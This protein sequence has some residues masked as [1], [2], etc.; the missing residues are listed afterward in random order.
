MREVSQEEFDD[1]ILRRKQIQEV[2][3][4][5]RILSNDLENIEDSELGGEA[6]EIIRTSHLD[7]TGAQIPT[8]DA[9]IGS[10]Y[11]VH[12]EDLTELDL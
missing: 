4:Y 1:F 12:Y 3:K 6:K 2:I 5:G 7:R 10:K 9:Q 8:S 11:L